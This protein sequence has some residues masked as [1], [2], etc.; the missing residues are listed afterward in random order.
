LFQDSLLT[1]NLLILIIITFM[2][3]H[4]SYGT[5]G[6]NSSEVGQ[7]N[8]TTTIPV[9]CNDRQEKCLPQFFV[10]IPINQTQIKEMSADDLN[11][12]KNMYATTFERYLNDSLEMIILDPMPPMDPIE[13]CETLPSPG[14]YGITPEP[15]DDD[16]L[17]PMSNATN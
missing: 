11:S 8:S 16:I 1:V 6:S 3:I 7:S 10:S 2:T 17:I 5:E 12:L 4:A 13:Y 14:C 9:L 15:E